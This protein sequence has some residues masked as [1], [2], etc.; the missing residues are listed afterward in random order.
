MRCGGLFCDVVLCG[1]S[2]GGKFIC[3]LGSVCGEILSELFCCVRLYCGVRF[4]GL[5]S[6]VPYLFEVS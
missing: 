4:A 6:C 3:C 5:V 1:V 2:F